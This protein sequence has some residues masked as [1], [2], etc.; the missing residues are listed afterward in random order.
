MTTWNFNV[1]QQQPKEQ[2]ESGCNKTCIQ[3]HRVLHYHNCLGFIKVGFLLL[4]GLSHCNFVANV[5]ELPTV[6][7]TSTPTAGTTK[8]T[9]EDYTYK[10]AGIDLM[11]F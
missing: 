10:H 4:L 6:S 8:T 11:Q 2:E 9:Y 7:A 5:G 3:F 1:Y